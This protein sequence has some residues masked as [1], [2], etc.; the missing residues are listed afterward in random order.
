MQSARCNEGGGATRHLRCTRSCCE[1]P[2]QQAVARAAPRRRCIGKIF[3]RLRALLAPTPERGRCT[4][5][6]PLGG[7]R[8]PRQRAPREFKRRTAHSSGSASTPSQADRSRPGSHT[9]RTPPGPLQRDGLQ[10]PMAAI[11]V[12]WREHTLEMHLLQHLLSGR[13]RRDRVAQLV[14]HVAR[15]GARRISSVVGSSAAQ[16]ATRPFTAAADRPA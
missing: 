8:L 15:L 3:G 2:R 7:P 5:G 4:R 11:A 13:P 9:I 14:P 12:L 16:R 10:P 1:P 6:H